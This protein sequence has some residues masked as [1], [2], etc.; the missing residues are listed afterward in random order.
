[1]ESDENNVQCFSSKSR[2]H[3]N[4][5]RI[6][7]SHIGGYEEFYYVLWIAMYSPLNESRRFAYYS[8]LKMEAIYSSEISVDFRR[9]TWHYIPED[10]TL[11]WNQYV[12]ATSEWAFPLFLQYL[13]LPKPLY[14]DGCCPLRLFVFFRVWKAESK[15]LLSHRSLFAIHK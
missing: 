14:Q 8:T 3:R 9:T 12:A 15:H 2:T 1:M 4:L 10:K 13:L 7:G 11:Y 5:C 6:W